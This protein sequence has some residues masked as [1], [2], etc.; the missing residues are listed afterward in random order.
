MDKKR[1]RA[2]FTKCEGNPSGVSTGHSV[3]RYSEENKECNDKDVSR[4]KKVKPPER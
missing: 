2:V 4:E 1:T 3:S